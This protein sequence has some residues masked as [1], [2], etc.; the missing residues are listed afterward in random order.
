MKPLNQENNRDEK[1]HFKPG[2]SGNPTGRTANTKGM[3]SYIDLKT[4]DMKTVIDKVLDM[5]DSGV[6][7]EKMFAVEWLS[8]RR[9][10]KATQ[11]IQSEDTTHV[12]IGPSVEDT[13]EE[14]DDNRPI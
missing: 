7:K 8:D 2:H 9:W 10:G 14:N 3:A 6:S 1:G 4:D 12:V 11:H 13:S 5:L